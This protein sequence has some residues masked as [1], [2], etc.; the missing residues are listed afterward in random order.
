[1]IAEKHLVNVEDYD[2]HDNEDMTRFEDDWIAASLAESAPLIAEMYRDGLIDA[3]GRRISTAVPP[4]MLN[5]EA[6]VEQQ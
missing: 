6:S 4:D 2:F 3:E 5:P 1:M